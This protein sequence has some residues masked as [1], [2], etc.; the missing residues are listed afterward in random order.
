MIFETLRWNG[1]LSNKGMLSAILSTQRHLQKKWKEVWNQKSRDCYIRKKKKKLSTPRMERETNPHSRLQANHFFHNDLLTLY[2][3]EYLGFLILPYK[4][5]YRK[6]NKIIWP[7]ALTHLDKFVRV[8]KQLGS[9]VKEFMERMVVNK[10][11]FCSKMRLQIWDWM[12]NGAIIE[13][14]TGEPRFRFIRI[15]IKPLVIISLL[16][17]QW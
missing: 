11:F 10:W 3:Y 9:H 1:G 14:N 5:L 17:K 12:K 7:R 15:P 13:G 8:A 6:N 4:L 2:Y 16:T